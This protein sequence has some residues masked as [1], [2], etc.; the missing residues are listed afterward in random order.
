MIVLYNAR[1]VIL[2]GEERDLV[3]EQSVVL[4]AQAVADALLSA[5][6]RAVLV[7]AHSHVEAILAPY[8]PTRWMVFNLHEGVVGRPFEEARLA[9]TLEALGYRFTGSDG[10]AIALSTHKGRFKSLLA[11]NGIPTPRWWLFRHPDEVETYA[12]DLTFPLIVKPVAEDASIGLGVDSV[13]S[14]V[15]ELR[16]RVAYLIERYRQMA[17]VEVYVDGRELNVGVWREPPQPLPLAEV[18]F[19]AFR[20][21]YKRIVS[22]EAKWMEDS[23]EYTHT[24]VLCPAPVDPVLSRQVVDIALKIWTLLGCRGYMRVDLRVSQ[25][26]VPYVVEANCNPDISPGAGFPNMARAAGYSYEQMVVH[27][28]EMARQYGCG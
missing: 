28:L 15:H 9:W 12:S 8:P 26:G 25:E 2:R 6:Y 22:F 10:N 24:P 1:H 14:T 4:C 20:D 11:A 5:G 13:V 7:P 21:P 3:A 17:L 27:I 23:F 19:S 16:R 18:D